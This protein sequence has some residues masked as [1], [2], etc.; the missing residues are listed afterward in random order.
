MNFLKH[1][2]QVIQ[3]KKVAALFGTAPGFLLQIFSG[4]ILPDMVNS[5]L[6]VSGLKVGDRSVCIGYSAMTYFII[7][8]AAV[9]GLGIA[10]YRILYIKVF[11]AMIT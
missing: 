8:Y 11:K 9:G 4:L 6:V 7:S 1:N 10:I 5:V 3:L 2:A